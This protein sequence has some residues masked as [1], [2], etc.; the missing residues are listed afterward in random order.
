[1]LKNIFP[2]LFQTSANIIERATTD[3]ITHNLPHT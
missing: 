1:M 2:T 3:Y